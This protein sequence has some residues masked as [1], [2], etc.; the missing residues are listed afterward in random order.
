MHATAAARNPFVMLTDPES[1]LRA[2]DESAPLKS[3]HTRICRP[4]DRQCTPKSDDD[5]T[6]VEFDAQVEGDPETAEGD[7]A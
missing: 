2:I 1:L 7:A 3:L 4:L 6:C 5:P